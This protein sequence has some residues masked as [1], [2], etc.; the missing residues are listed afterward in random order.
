MALAIEVGLRA[1]SPR[2]EQKRSRGRPIE[3]AGVVAD[4]HLFLLR[5]R[6]PERLNLL[7]RLAMDLADLPLDD[8]QLRKVIDDQ[9]R[10]NAKKSGGWHKPITT[11]FA[12]A[13]T[14]EP[15]WT[16]AIVADVR[17]GRQQLA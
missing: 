8:L 11:G 17:S 3:P 12:F 9:G 15:I 13:P 4:A 16:G 5:L 2:T 6:G 7:V 1:D 14:R 10:E